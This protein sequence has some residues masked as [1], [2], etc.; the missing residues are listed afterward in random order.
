M[1][2]Y[3]KAGLLNSSQTVGL[4]LQPQ[5]WSVY[6]CKKGELHPM[7]L[8]SFYYLVFIIT[9]TPSQNRAK[10]LPSPST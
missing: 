9:S 2:I 3:Q 1:H 8:V 6:L 7:P 10:Q 5:K 4:V